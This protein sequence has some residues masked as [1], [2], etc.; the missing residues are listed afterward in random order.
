MPSDDIFR[1]RMTRR[2]LLLGGAA[3]LVAGAAT[4]VGIENDLLPGRST[5]YRVLGLDGPAGVIPNIAPGPML[6]GSFTSVKRLG[7]TV[8]WAISYPP[9]SKPGVALPVL[10][11]LHGVG[12][13]SS[14]SFGKGLG[15][16]RFLAQCIK[17]GSPPFALASIDGGNT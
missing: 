8:N 1:A 4:A 6:S 10:I 15:L 17:K 5:L 13:N 12:G 7:A 3:V 11:S 2:G 16:D 14:S 9:G